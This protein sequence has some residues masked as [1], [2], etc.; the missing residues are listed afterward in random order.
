MQCK[1]KLELYSIYAVYITLQEAANMD[2]SDLL[3][4]AITLTYNLAT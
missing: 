3:S 2:W 4:W 1:L